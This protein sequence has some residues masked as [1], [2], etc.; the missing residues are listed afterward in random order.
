MLVS[1]QAACLTHS[2]AS[3]GEHGRELPKGLA[4]MQ[5]MLWL[6]SGLVCVAGICAE[7]SVTAGTVHIHWG[8][9]APER[10]AKIDIEK[11]ERLL[12][13]RTADPLKFDLR[14]PFYGRVLSDSKLADKLVRRWERN[15]RRFEYWHACLWGVLNGYA[16]TH[17][18]VPPVIVSPPPDSNNNG[19]GGGPSPTPEPSTWVLMLIGLAFVAVRVHSLGPRSG[20]KIGVSSFF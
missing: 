12:A 14:R 16:L 10:Y 11:Y 9:D 19:P 4:S 13:E 5:T 8:P 1:M 2:Q 20:Q 18:S 3:T 6:A 7:G 15:E 17:P